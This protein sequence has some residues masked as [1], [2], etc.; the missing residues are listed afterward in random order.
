MLQKCLT[1]TSTTAV[2]ATLT[3]GD[4]IEKW[5]SSDTKVAIVTQKGKLK[6]RKVGTAV[7]TVTTQRGASAS[8]EVKVRKTKVATEKLKLTN[9]E[10]YKLTLKKGKTFTIKTEL[11]PL[12]SQEKITYKS[13]DKKVAKVSKTGKIKAV[14]EGKTVITVK[15]GNVMV[16]VK[17]SVKKK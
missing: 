6:A 10:N 8:V 7:I 3:K 4:S 16:K 13:S 11:T 9:I 5:E 17:V 1:T 15:S 2:K 14:K 12:T